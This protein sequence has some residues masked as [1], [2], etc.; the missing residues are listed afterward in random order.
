MEAMNAMSHVII[1]ESITI[2]RQY[3]PGLLESVYE[4][5]LARA[6]EQRGFAVRRQHCVRLKDGDLEFE[7]AFRADL[8]V[9]NAIIIEIKST[10]QVNPVHARQLLTYLRLTGIQLGLV[11]NFGQLTLREGLKRVINTPS[12]SPLR[13]SAAPS[14][15]ENTVQ[16]NLKEP[17]QA[18][19]P[20]T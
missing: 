5:L 20:D 17:H 19:R 3:G 6:L 18:P 12:S 10:A 14:L 2:H 9:E 11:I 13:I 7:Q 1:E 4:A 15:R 8:I 16:T